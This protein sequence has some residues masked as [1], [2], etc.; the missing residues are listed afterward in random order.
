MYAD[1]YYEPPKPSPND[2]PKGELLPKWTLNE[3]LMNVVNAMVSTIERHLQEWDYQ[4]SR[5]GGDL[6][7]E[8][9]AYLEH[10]T[11]GW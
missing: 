4:A 11:E 5:M 9:E 10:E 8:T 6:V 7:N 1:P 2:H 3:Q